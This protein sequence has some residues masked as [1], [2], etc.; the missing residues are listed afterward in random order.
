MWLQLSG[1]LNRCQSETPGCFW[2]RLVAKEGL[3]SEFK[4]EE[5]VGVL[6]FGHCL[7]LNSFNEL[8]QY[9]SN[10]KITEIIEFVGNFQ[11]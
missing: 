5:I 9:I 2:P 10:I 1:T 4:L 8:T 3:F 7:S 11:A 6:F